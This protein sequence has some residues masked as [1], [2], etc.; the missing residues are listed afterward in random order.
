MREIGAL[1]LVALLLD[2]HLGKSACQFGH[3][4]EAPDVCSKSHGLGAE[5]Y[6]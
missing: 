6:D 4:V 5:L 1:V 2:D 3:M